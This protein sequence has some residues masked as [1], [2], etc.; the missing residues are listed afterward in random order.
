MERT[1]A[2]ALPHLPDA[3]D[4]C[5]IDASF[6]SLEKVIPAAVRQL[7]PGGRI[8]ALLK[9][10]FQGRRQEI[11]KGGVVREPQVHAAIIARFV[12]WAIERRL[13]VLGMTA[14]PLLGPAGNREFLLLLG[15]QG[16]E[17]EGAGPAPDRHV[18]QRAGRRKRP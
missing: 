10:Q 4:V 11:G 17:I 2:R 14:S 18:R 7:R 12:A 15:W 8:I 16:G 9:P 3:I 6:I 1:N 5:T 13:W